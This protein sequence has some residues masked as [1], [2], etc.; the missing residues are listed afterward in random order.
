MDPDWEPEP[1]TPPAPPGH[2]PSSMPGLDGF[3][4]STPASHLDASVSRVK[5]EGSPVHSPAAST[6]P[7]AG[8]GL[9]GSGSLPQLLLGGSSVDGGSQKR[10]ADDSSEGTSGHSRKQRKLSDSAPAAAGPS[11]AL[12]D[13]Q[14]TGAAQQ[15]HIGIHGHTRVCPGCEKRWPMAEY[16]PI[17]GGTGER[18]RCRD[19]QV[20]RIRNSQAA[21]AGPASSSVHNRPFASNYLDQPL[22][23]ARRGRGVPKRPRPITTLA[24]AQANV[25]KP[26]LLAARGTGPAS[27]HQSAHQA[28]PDSHSGAEGKVSRVESH[29]IRRPHGLIG[30]SHYPMA[31]SRR[32]YD[33]YQRVF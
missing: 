8:E 14:D 27:T 30:V 20:A 22:P 23:N 32:P 1:P 5:V 29:E 3:P 16:Q 19:C 15:Q 10:S 28:P 21:A 33:Y 12:F 26:I 4:H 25:A 17:D 18:D 24:Q 13:R 9:I 11:V 6:G 2:E 31:T 7:H